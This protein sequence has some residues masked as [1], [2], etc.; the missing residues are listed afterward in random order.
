MTHRLQLFDTPQ[1]LAQSVTQFLLEGYERGENLLIAAKRRNL[2]AILA[3]LEAHHCFS[4]DHD[5]Q[6]LVAL[7]ATELLTH[8]RRNGVIDAL[9]FEAEIGTL[10]ERLSVSG[11]LRVYGEI[12]E[13]LAEEGDFDGAVTLETLWNGLSERY[14]FTLMCGYSSAHFSSDASALRRICDTHNHV[15]ACTDDTLGSYLLTRA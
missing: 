10:V 6:R 1:S 8:L 3:A 13:V 7:D 9:R 15:S 14:P 11:P 12:V 5:R 2:D 4:G